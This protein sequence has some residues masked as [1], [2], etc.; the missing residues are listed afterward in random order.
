M[1]K[2][3]PIFAVAVFSILAGA[4]CNQPADGAKDDE[5][6]DD[7]VA[8]VDADRDGF[9]AP[10]DCDDFNNTIYPGARERSYDG[11]DSNC[12]G[13]ELP[14]LGDNQFE[15]GLILIDI[16]EDG[17]ISLDEFEA[18]CAQGALL[19]DGQPGVVSTQ[20]KCGGTSACRGMVLHPWNELFV[21]DCRGINY[22]AGWSCTEAAADKGR[23][24]ATAYAEGNCT[25]CH[26][27]DE[28][29]F[30]VPVPE[31]Q[32]VEATL[33]GFLDRSDDRFRAAIAF[34]VSGI[35]PGDV[36]YRN[37]PSHYE[38]LSR[39]EMDAVIAFVRTQPLHGVAYALGDV[40]PDTEPEE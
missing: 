26:T 29:G 6:N 14:L 40:D 19:L 35:S 11:V 34:G 4:A 31:G 25:M 32:D 21:H 16:D 30:V 18:A 2:R 7:D 10:E 12:D 37:M 20:A 39:A 13:E 8:V 27:G 15:A 33:A 22:C 1:W 9:A 3:R 24:G 23:D 36:A 28:P 5:E 38:V 17:A